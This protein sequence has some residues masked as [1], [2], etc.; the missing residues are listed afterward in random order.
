MRFTQVLTGIALAAALA[1]G[2]PAVAGVG[3]Q[4]SGSAQLS[5]E[6]IESRVEALLKKDSLLAPRSIDV[7][8]ERGRVTLTGTVKTA[9][10]KAHAAIVAKIE[11]VSAVVNELEVDP[12]VA[13]SKT[14]RAAARTKEGLNKAV[15]ATAKGVEKAKEGVQVG[16]AE[17]AKGVG[18]AADKTGEVLGTAGEKLSDAAV[19]TR[20]KN[21]LSKDPLLKDTSIAVESAAH[22]VTLRGTVV[23]AAVKTKAEDIA[24]STDG[25]ARVVSEIVVRP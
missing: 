5:D 12:N 15:D 18:K 4:A 21:N 9:G 8:S 1:V 23:S 19:V 13:V 25:V 17:A 10:E 3:A 14:D 2:S 20:V 22:V 11:G 7:E 6:T 24:K 16:V